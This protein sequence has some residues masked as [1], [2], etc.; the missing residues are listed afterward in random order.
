[1]IP[2]ECDGLGAE[3]NGPYL[4]D[5]HRGSEPVSLGDE[6]G[7]VYGVKLEGY[8]KV[9]AAMRLCAGPIRVLYLVPRAMQQLSRVSRADLDYANISD[10]VS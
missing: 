9:T 8:A 4:A 3:V 5:E 6:G 2:C 7:G 10:F 1:M